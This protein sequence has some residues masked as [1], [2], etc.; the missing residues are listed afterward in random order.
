MFNVM[1]YSSN[2][3]IVWYIFAGVGFSNIFY[4]QLS[5]LKIAQNLSLVDYIDV[6]VNYSDVQ[7]FDE[8][9]LAIQNT[10]L[11]EKVNI[12]KVDFNPDD[13]SEYC[14]INHI[15]NLVKFNPY[16]YNGEF[17]VGYIHLKGVSYYSSNHFKYLMSLDW[18]DFL[19]WCFIENLDFD[20]KIIKG[21]KFEVIGANMQKYLYKGE[22]RNSFEGNFWIATSTYIHKLPIPIK[23]DLLI[24]KYGR[25]HKSSFRLYYEYWITSIQGNFLSLYKSH[26]IHE[27]DFHYKNRILREHYSKTLRLN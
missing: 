2:H 18:G 16:K 4:R 10:F 1:H 23:P 24:Q 3:I 20:L 5:K 11:D 9:K 6:I 12:I 7:K 14:A 22:R 27:P 13:P 8:I 21:Q 26:S 19:E 17:T 15:Y 25:D